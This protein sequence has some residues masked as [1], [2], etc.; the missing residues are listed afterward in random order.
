MA[1]S[2]GPG[3]PKSPE[4]KRVT[5][6]MKVSE[7][8]AAAIDTARGERNRS[9]W[10]EQAADLMLGQRPLLIEDEP[11]P[12]AFFDERDLAVIASYEDQVPLDATGEPCAHPKARVIKGLCGACGTRP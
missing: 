3:R 8:K 2:N 9:E 10:L 12:V 4:G 11:P 1:T 7:Q 5:V 6:C